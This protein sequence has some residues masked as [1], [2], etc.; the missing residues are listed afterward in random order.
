[1][2]WT[3]LSAKNEKCRA[4]FG[5]DFAHSVGIVDLDKNKFSLE[6][7][8]QA[9]GF[10]VKYAQKGIS[11]HIVPTEEGKKAGIEPYGNPHHIVNPMLEVVPQKGDVVLG[12]YTNGS[13]RIGD[14]HERQISAI[15]QR[16]KFRFRQGV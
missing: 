6:A 14:V 10:K 8:E 2:H 11:V 12:T 1:M 16:S 5:L 7:V 9:T 3:R 15:F 13:S 4:K